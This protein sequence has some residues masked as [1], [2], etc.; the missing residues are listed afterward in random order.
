MLIPSSHFIQIAF[1]RLV[2]TVFS[3]AIVFFLSFLFAISKEC[4][5]SWAEQFCNHIQNLLLQI[6][7]ISYFSQLQ[8]TLDYRFLLCS[9]SR[10]LLRALAQGLSGHHFAPPGG[11]RGELRSS[12][13]G[14]CQAQDGA[15]RRA[16]LA[17]LRGSGCPRLAAAR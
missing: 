2:K 11:T 12:C 14:P 4:S 13:L 8:S 16:P 5:R 10:G 9:G 1:H 6:Q 17:G 15:E 7:N 3:K